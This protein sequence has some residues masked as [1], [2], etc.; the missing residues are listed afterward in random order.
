VD[1]GGGPSYNPRQE[2]TE[3]FA[4]IANYVP[5]VFAVSSYEMYADHKNGVQNDVT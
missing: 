3:S 5:Q 4:K 2:N 1:R